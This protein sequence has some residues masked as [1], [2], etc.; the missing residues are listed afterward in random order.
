MSLHLSRLLIPRSCPWGVLRFSTCFKPGAKDLSHC[1][2]LWDV[3]HCLHRANSRTLCT[4]CQQCCLI[5]CHSGWHL[6]NESSLPT[7]KLPTAVPPP[8][9]CDQP[10]QPPC[11]LQ[12]CT[13]ARLAG[14]QVLRCKFSQ[15]DPISCHTCCSAPGS[16]PATEPSTKPCTF[17]RASIRT[18]QL[19]I[20]TSLPRRTFPH[21]DCFVHTS[22]TRS[23][24]TRPVHHTT[25]LN[26]SRHNAA[27]PPMQVTLNSHSPASPGHTAITVY[28]QH[29]GPQHSPQKHP[30]HITNHQH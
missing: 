20:H 19:T 14:A 26:H 18:N 8:W 22:P 25:A 28:I 24:Q 6:L 13:E 5:N 2:L 12:M 16:C 29:R 15:P 4:F 3:L 30:P 1:C 11:L 9:P 27:L 7:Y 21:A 17:P 23:Q 10:L